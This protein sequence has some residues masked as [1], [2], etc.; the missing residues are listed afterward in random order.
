MILQIWIPVLR[1]LWNAFEEMDG[2]W[3]MLEQQ[4]AQATEERRLNAETIAG[5]GESSSHHQPFGIVEESLA[6]LPSPLSLQ[7]NRCGNAASAERGGG[8]GSPDPARDEE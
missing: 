7:G 2:N 4:L 3:D 5:T 8:R 6:S 1:N